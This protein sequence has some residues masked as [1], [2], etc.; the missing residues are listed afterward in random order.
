VTA[1]LARLRDLR[2]E[3]LTCKSVYYDWVRTL[4]AA[5]AF[6]REHPGLARPPGFSL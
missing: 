6:Q 1:G 3:L 2:F 5:R 4:A